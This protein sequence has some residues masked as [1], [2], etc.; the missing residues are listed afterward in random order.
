MKHSF[1]NRN[2]VVP[3]LEPGSA[4]TGALSSDWVSLAHGAGVAIQIVIEEGRAAAADDNTIT[5]RQAKDAA[6]D[7]PIDLVPRR[8]YRRSSATSLA[9]AAAAT[10]EVIERAADGSLDMHVDGDMTTIYDIE[11]DASELDV[12]ND[13]AFIQAR[14]AAVGSSTT[15]VSMT[16]I[17]C[18]LFQVLAPEHLANVLA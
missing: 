14:T 1:L 12:N 18:G 16:A 4:T 5:L 8:A 2:K 15:Q 7:D 10:P 17:A 11:I 13:Y 3:I 6:G 9:D